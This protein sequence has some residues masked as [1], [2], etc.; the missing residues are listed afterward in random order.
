MAKIVLSE[1]APSGEAI[2]FSLGA[3]EPFNLGGSEKKSLT[4]NDPALLADAAA[5]PWLTVEHDKVDAPEPVFRS[6]SVNPEDDVLS[7]AYKGRATDADAPQAEEVPHVA[8]DAG[9]DQDEKVVTGE[10]AET[11]A[12][13]ETH[14]G[15]K[16]AAKTT[17]SKDS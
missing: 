4:T 10:V 15:A 11:L 13:D 14:K 1:V 5:H 7:A 6:A 17:D 12:A 16:R 2:R 9:K 8:I 3:S